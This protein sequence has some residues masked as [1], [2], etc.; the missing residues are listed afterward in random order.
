MTRRTEPPR[1]AR[2]RWQVEVTNF[3]DEAIGED[4][5]GASVAEQTQLLGRTESGHGVM[6]LAMAACG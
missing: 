6:E 4:V 3:D 1:S 2:M 5:I